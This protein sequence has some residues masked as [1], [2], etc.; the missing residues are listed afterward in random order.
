MNKVIFLTTIIAT[1]VIGGFLYWQT[2]EGSSS[3]LPKPQTPIPPYDYVVEDFEVT[4]KDQA[5]ILS[6]TLTVPNGEG[7]FPAAILLSVA[8]PN[9][10]DQ[11]FADHKGFHVLADYLTR[12]GVAVARFDDRNVGG[13]SG[14]YFDSSWGDFT[15]DALAIFTWLESD[16]RIDSDRIGVIGMSQGAA[17]GALAVS[18]NESI[19]YAVLLSAPGLPGEEALALQLEKLLEISRVSGDRADR[20]RNLFREF[21]DIVKSD[22]AD[23]TR[24]ERMNE[25][26]HGPGRALIPPYQFMPSDTDGL[27]KVLLGPWYHSNVNFDP[28]TAYGSLAV[29]ILAVAGEKDFVAPPN[30]HLEN[31]GI[32]LASAPTRDVTVQELPGLNHLLQEAETGLPTEY[33]TLENSFSPA[34]LEIIANWISN[35]P[36]ERLEP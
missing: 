20:Y 16:A 28:L 8:G 24:V 11:S 30:R 25:F 36:K 19:A 13:S 17:I 34:A 32:I 10:R 21:M 9:D 1:T 6:G 33:A 22:P 26:L 14:D 4:S 2:M 35:R 5:T 7:P 3:D 12:N 15:N 29:P 18:A 31:I 27:I 23:P